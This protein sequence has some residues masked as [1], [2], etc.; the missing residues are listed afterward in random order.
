[1]EINWISYE[2]YIIKIK[3]KYIKGLETAFFEPDAPHKIPFIAVFQ[4]LSAIIPVT[5]VE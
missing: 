4:Y 1:M 5:Y 3:K 2:K